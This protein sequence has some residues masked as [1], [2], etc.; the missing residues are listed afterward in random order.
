M[1]DNNEDSNSDDSEQ[2]TVYGINQNDLEN[3]DLY[4]E[5]DVE[6]DEN[7]EYYRDYTNYDDDQINFDTLIE[8]LVSNIIATN[9]FNSFIN[10]SIISIDFR[11]PLESVLIESLILNQP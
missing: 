3:D 8:H 6:Y 2:H 1:S 9:R 5:Y 11:D 7:D 4:E 10:N